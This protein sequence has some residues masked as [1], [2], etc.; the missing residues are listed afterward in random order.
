MAELDVDKLFVS[1]IIQERDLTPVANVPPNFLFNK[2]YREAYTYIRQYFNDHATV[3]TVR[4]MSADCP[5]IKLVTV[6]EPWDDLIKRVETKY[7]SGILAEGLSEVSD[8]YESGDIGEVINFLGVLV[9]KVHT[10]IP[11]KRDVDATKTGEERL[12]RYQERRDNPG[13]MVG[14]PSGYPTI[15]KATQGFQPGQLITATGLPK[16]SK[17]AL[18]MTFA[19]AAQEYGKRVLYLTFEMTCSEQ[20]NRLDAYRAGFNDN[21]LNSGELTNEDMENLRRSI[22]ITESLP[23]LIFSE[24]TDT[25]TAIGAKIDVT[26]ADVVIVDGVYMME[27]EHG[28]SKGSP[29]ALANIV[30]GLKFLA[31]RRKIC[32]IAVTQST[33]ARTKGEVLNNDSIMGSRAFIQYSNVVIG[34]ERIPEEKKFRKLKIIMSRSCAPCEFV[35]MFDFDTGTYQ[36]MADVELDIDDEDQTDYDE[37]AF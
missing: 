24:D 6:E 16:V 2:D 18:A 5:A 11:N 10:V 36:E 4:I 32:I 14:V 7:L 37:E 20:T 34:I 22:H 25:V 33:P 23:P 13:V 31:M 12:A 21:K 15:D 28:E 26:E 3:P 27:D 29:Q 30:Q 19:M 17:S 1:K 8:S 9:S 35:V